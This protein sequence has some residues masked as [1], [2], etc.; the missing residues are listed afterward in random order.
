MDRDR[1]LMG[2]VGRPHGVRGLVHVH[3]Y[4]AVPEDLARYGVL[5]DEHGNAWHLSWRGK[6]IAE[7]RDG[8]G[9]A[10]SSREDAQKLVNRKLYVGR[11]DLPE[12]EEDEFYVA[13]LVGMQ[14]IEQGSTPS[15]ELGHVRLV[16]DYGAGVSL[17]ITGGEE[18]TVLLPFTRACVPVVDMG[19][20]RIEVVLPDEIEVPAEYFP[21]DGAAESVA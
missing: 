15:R 6:G 4:A 9:Q 7:L 8:A 18:G 3:T 13:D 11:A 12:P 1:I 5:R 17:E 2:V 20:R 10:V 14:V 19:A 21:G 16:H